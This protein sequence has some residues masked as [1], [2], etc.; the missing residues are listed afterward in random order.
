MRLSRQSK[1][2]LS[3]GYVDCRLICVVLRCGERRYKRALFSEARMENEALGTFDVKVSPIGDDDE[4]I[5][6]MSINRT[7]HG[8]LKRLTAKRI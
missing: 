4:P 6:G 8:D 1:P 3:K 2:D 7:F 5:G